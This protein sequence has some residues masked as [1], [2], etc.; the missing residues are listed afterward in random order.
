MQTYQEKQTLPFSHQ[1]LFDLV[2]NIE[3]YPQFLPWCK[4][5]RILKRTNDHLEAT[6]KVG[7]TPFE[8][9]FTSKVTWGQTSPK[10]LWIKTSAIKGPIDKLDA[11][12]TFKEIGNHT[13]QCELN[14]EMTY[15]A[16]SGLMNMVMDKVFQTIAQSMIHA[17]RKRAGEI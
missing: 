17:F 1:K 3:D 12:W 7:Y 16:P 13:G 5:A 4:G 2:M 15:H 14:Y 8:E 9:S 10:S 11:L 6:L